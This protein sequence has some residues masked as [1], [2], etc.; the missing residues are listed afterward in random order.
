MPELYLVVEAVECHGLLRVVD[1]HFGLQ[2][3]VHALHGGQTLRNVVAGLAELLER[4]DDGVEHH[5]V[6]DESRAA[7]RVVVQYE[8]APHPKHDD[9]HHRAQKLAHRMGQLLSDVHTHHV[10]TVVAVHLVEAFV[11]LLFR[12]EGLD[13]AQT[14]QRLFHL[15]HRVAPQQLRLDGVLF[16]FPAHQPHE[17]SEHGHEDNGEKRQLPGDEQERGEVGY[18]EDRV[19]EKHVETRHDAVFY[20]L[21]IAAHTGYDVALALF[22][23][24]SE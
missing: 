2:Y 15:T 5:E 10:V 20:L 16:E 17:P 1:G 12:T 9:D 21:H 24:E 4:I 22:A 13:D 19:L 23:E 6:V 18:D 11:H 3:L 7:Q 8:N 14:A